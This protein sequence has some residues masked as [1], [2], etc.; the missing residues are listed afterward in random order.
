M[1]LSKLKYKVFSFRL[2]D[3]THVSLKD[4]KGDLSWNKFFYRLIKCYEH[5]IRSGQ[6]DKVLSDMRPKTNT[7]D[8]KDSKGRNNHREGRP[9]QLQS[10]WHKRVN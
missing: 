2:N 8:N 4:I 1:K 3:K 7:R 9:L 5:T 6:L 10:D